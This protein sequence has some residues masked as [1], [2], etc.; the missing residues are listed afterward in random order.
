MYIRSSWTLQSRF[1]A[2]AIIGGKKIF[3]RESLLVFFYASRENR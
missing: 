1:G 2:G 3:Q